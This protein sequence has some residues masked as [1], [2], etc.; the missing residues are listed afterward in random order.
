MI[1]SLPSLHAQLCKRL[2]AWLAANARRPPHALPAD[3][4]AECAAAIGLPLGPEVTQLVDQ[5]QRWITLRAIAKPDADWPS[6]VDVVRSDLFRRIR[7]GLPVLD[8]Q[9]P[10]AQSELWYDLVLQRGPHRADD[11]VDTDRQKVDPESGVVLRRQW[12][13]VVEVLGEQRFLLAVDDGRSPHRFVLWRDDHPDWK[14]HWRTFRFE[15]RR[16]LRDG[17]LTEPIRCSI[18]TTP[19]RYLW[20]VQNAAFVTDTTVLTTQENGHEQY[21]MD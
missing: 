18:E 3:V 5:L 16:L 12:Y 11:G 1:T 6:L 13:R 10:R 20:W 21:K 15:M 19:P 2:C 9:P 7:S 8:Y 17:K 4:V 14:P